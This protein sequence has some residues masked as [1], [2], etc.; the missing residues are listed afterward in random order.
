MGAK[1]KKLT[2]YEMH[3]GVKHVDG[4][5]IRIAIE[6]GLITPNDTWFEA[7][8]SEE[9]AIRYLTEEKGLDL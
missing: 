6:E 8:T 9:E 3:D 1:T 4:R 5:K 2:I 7:G